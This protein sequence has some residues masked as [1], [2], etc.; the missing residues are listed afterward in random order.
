MKI[1]QVI[2]STDIC[3][4]CGQTPCNCTH[5]TESAGSVGDT[6][7][8]IYQ[9]F[10]DQG[11]DALEYLNTHAENFARYWD[12][13]EGD[14]DSMIEELPPKILVKLAQELQSVAAQEGLEEGLRDPAD[15]PCWK[16]YH[17]VGTKK[18]NGRTV[19]NCV[20]N[21]NEGVA[22][23]ELATYLVSVMDSATGEHWRIEVKVTSPEA[24]K[25][26]AE[27]MGYKVLGVE[28]KQGV[29]EGPAFDKWAD[30]RVAS[31]LHKLKPKADY[32][33][34]V[35][36]SIKADRIRSLKNLIAIAREQ[37][38][39]LRVQELE[40]ELKKLQGV[41]EGIGQD[42][43]KL[44]GI[45]AV[46]IGAGLAGNYYDQQQPRVEVGGQKAYLVQN[47]GWGR[48]P[49]N[50]MT[51][52]GKDG[53]TYTVWAQKGKGTTQYYATPAEVKE[54]LGKDLKRL[55]TGKDVKS[56]AGQEIAKAQQASMTGDNKTANKHF[57]RYDKLDTLAN[58]GVA[59]DDA[60][61]VEQ[62]FAV[63][64]EK[65]KQRLARLKQTDPE[66]YKREMAKRKTSSRI[67]PVSTFEQQ[68]VAEERNKQGY[69]TRVQKGKFLPSKYGEDEYN[70]LHDL[71]NSSYD[72][73]G[74]VLVTID[75]KRIAREIAAMY[76]GDV[77]QTGLGTYRIVQRK[78]AAPVGN[79]TPELTGVA[80]GEK[81]GHMDADRFDDAVARLKKLAGAGP[82]KTVWDPQKRVYK[83]VP[84]AQQPGDKK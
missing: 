75:D 6:I 33:P 51:L 68:G 41:D 55:A 10:Y 66:A 71:M 70:Y 35:K 29:A 15:N 23:G 38:R 19:P 18:K 24:A 57:K 65:E 22:E 9:Q 80:E 58:K 76:G 34:M 53:K 84:V 77:E 64:M 31:Q 16:G 52:Q 47:P 11:D 32:S 20:P 1:K 27:A 56:R 13:Y 78:G 21:A 42:M 50:A 39:Q 43:A 67:P 74:P 17:P 59:E 37:G 2:E 54:G 48:I 26:R 8:L 40:L 69:H 79:K 3:R 4:V 12:R 81:V 62:R 5:I 28:E 83:N 82:L 61:D 46:G 60:G 63:K 36:D 49:D 14:L 45:A 72:G 73:E 7:R 25:E 44:G 30:E